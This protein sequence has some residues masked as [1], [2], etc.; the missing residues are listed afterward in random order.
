MERQIVTAT[1]S[2]RRI[3]LQDLNSSL[4]ERGYGDKSEGRLEL[5]P[6]EALY[7]I[8]EGWLEVV[9]DKA[10]KPVGFEELLNLYRS[11]DG[12]IW[13]RYLIYRDL[14]ERGYVVKQG[15]GLGVDFRVYERGAYG[16]DAA[17]YIVYGIFEGEP[18]PVGD[19][20]EALNYSR[21]LKK[22][23]VLGVIERRGELVYYS[24]SQF[25]L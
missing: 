8:A 24:L 22:D 25:N 10:K 16:K 14:R 1:L 18:L 19:L 6:C 17:Q 12:K 21:N 2:G 13:A 23:M 4:L 15:F 7:L 11:R 3:Y 5:A 9:D 20:V